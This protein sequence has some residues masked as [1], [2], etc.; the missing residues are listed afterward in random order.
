MVGNEIHVCHVA[1]DSDTVTRSELCFRLRLGYPW[2]GSSEVVNLVVLHVVFLG[3][4]LE[5]LPPC[6][7]HH[8]VPVLE[9]VGHMPHIDRV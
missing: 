4:F 9:P 6:T 7:V 8:Q 1:I 5:V 2:L 3:S